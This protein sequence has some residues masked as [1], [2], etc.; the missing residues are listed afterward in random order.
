M[1]RLDP[2]RSRRLAAL[3]KTAVVP[4]GPSGDGGTDQPLA[5]AWA[6]PSAGAQASGARPAA[7][8][9]RVSRETS[10]L[11]LCDDYGRRAN[12]HPV[13]ASR[14][15]RGVGAESARRPPASRRT[16]RS[17]RS[18]SATLPPTT[19]ARG[20]PRPPITWRLTAHEGRHP[21]SLLAG[22]AIRLAP[23]ASQRV[24]RPGVGGIP[25]VVGCRFARLLWSLPKPGASPRSTPAIAATRP[26]CWPDPASRI[27]R[28]RCTRSCPPR[29]RP[30]CSWHRRRGRLRGTR[31][32]RGWNQLTRPT[33]DL[34]DRT[35]GAA[36]RPA[37][38]RSAERTSGPPT[39]PKNPPA[40]SG[41]RGTA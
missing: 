23:P 35:A 41:S 33:G 13:L 27:P 36:S 22:S 28:R 40:M 25:D 11:Q 19:R 21:V 17:A 6:T 3:A 29:R 2:R 16:T 31:P 9:D 37:A 12:D 34:R 32:A 5:C 10:W 15:T 8:R 26:Y 20:S 4:V 14:R 7:G 24:A 39:M 18:E 38:R 30:R 1:F